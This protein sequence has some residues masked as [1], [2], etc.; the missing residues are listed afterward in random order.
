MKKECL[1]SVLAGGCIGLGGVAFL[2]LDNKVLGAL[3]F[4]LGLFCV[5]TLQLHLFTGKVCYLFLN[6]ALRMRDLAVI[7]L[8]NL[9]GTVCI[10]AVVR[11]SRISPL[12]AKAQELC[13][14][15]LSDT[16]WSLFLLAVMCNI[17]IYI[18]VE[19]FRSNPHE[20]GKYLALFFAVMGF[21][22]CGFEHCVADMFYFAVANLWSGEV[23]V[24]LLVI[25]MGNAVGGIIF[26]HLH[27]YLLRE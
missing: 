20:A 24:R 9:A 3:L 8:G 14:V 5:C 25:T 7:W 22:L 17:F 13:A 27:A 2:S 18:G 19:N 23:L 21:I 6:D 1:G 16:H 10:A 15:K 4:T 12:A 26:A 11:M